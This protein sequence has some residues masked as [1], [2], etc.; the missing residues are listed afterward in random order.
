MGD[1]RKVKME[2]KKRRKFKKK[3][4]KK[5]ANLLVRIYFLKRVGDVIT[6]SV[7][8]LK[9]LLRTALLYKVYILR[10]R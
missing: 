3:K 9:L 5:G 2:T 4:K 10:R 8:F 1:G 6:S 7:T